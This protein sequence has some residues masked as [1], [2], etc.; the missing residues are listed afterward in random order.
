MKNTFVD[1]FLG[2]GIL[3]LFVVTIITPIIIGYNIRASDEDML[4]E[5]C[6]FTTYQSAD[7]LECN[8]NSEAVAFSTES[9]GFIL[10]EKEHPKPILNS[11][12]LMNSSWPMKC[13]DLHHTGRSPIG[14]SGN[15]YDEL[16][17]FEFDY[18]GDT[19]PAIGPDGIIYVGGCTDVNKDGLFAFYQNG[20]IKWRY[21]VDDIIYRC[22]PAIAEDGTVYIASWDDCLHAVNPNGTRKWTIDS[23]G[24]IVSSPAIGSDGTIYFGTMWGTG[25]GGEIFAINPDGTEKWHYQTGYDVCSDPAVGDDGTIYIGSSDD[26]LYA[27]YPNGSLRWRYKTGDWVRG[28]PSIADDGTIYFG[29]WDYYLY[30]L[31]P[32]GTLRWKTEI[33]YG[34]ETNPTIGLDGTIYICS[35]SK[36]FAIEPDNG[37][38]L[39]EF[40]LGGHSAKSSPAICAD[41]IIYIGIRIG[42]DDGGEIV[43]VNS[44]GTEHWRHRL[45]NVDADSS[46]AIGSDGTIYICSR[47]FW[48]SEDWGHLHAFNRGDLLADANGPYLGVINLPVQITGFASGG[49]LPYSY[50]WD[51]GDGE[52]SEEQNPIHEYKAAGNYTVTLTVSDDNQTTASDTTF[53]IIRE[54]ND[55]PII[56]IIDG[57][58]QGFYGESYDYTFITTD[59]DGDDVYYYIDWGDGD[60]EEWIGP[61]NSD[62]IVTKSHTWDQE[63]TYTIRAKAKDVFDSES[64][65]GTLEVTMPVNQPTE[66]PII[67]W[68]L[69]RFPN[70]FPFLRRSL[71]L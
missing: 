62:E 59:I 16:W 28:P 27:L 31:Y 17:K 67:H 51:F 71:D 19:S 3:I 30:A 54:S 66:F 4:N 38:I 49:Y 45:S 63:D 60:V 39:W 9:A 29:S 55:P 12:G 35:A 24:N 65:W 61:Y 22:C 34:S 69:D 43:A 7:V 26:Y 44:D 8:C 36:L 41:G 18:L 2:I 68:L 33:W 64:E 10:N 21:E 32:D 40:N 53:A 42:T 56:P 37:D 57:E 58:T 6:V 23:N 5:K 70:M 1:I 50:F 20:T 48:S 14:T 25:N 46:P 52:T 15:P 47:S 13:H 11:N